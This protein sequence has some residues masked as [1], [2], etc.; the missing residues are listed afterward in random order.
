MENGP[1]IE[2]GC[3]GGCAGPFLA[4]IAQWEVGVLSHFNRKKTRKGGRE[5]RKKGKKERE[6]NF[7]FI[8]NVS[9][10]YKG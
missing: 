10:R 3:S 5:S 9:L 6:R 7:I 4:T 8:N 2:Q 1:R